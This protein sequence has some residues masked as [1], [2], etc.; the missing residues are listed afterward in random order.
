MVAKVKAQS[1]D[2]EIFMPDEMEMFLLAA[3]E[4]LIPYIAIIFK[5]YR[6]LATETQADEWFGI[7]PKEDQFAELGVWKHRKR[8]KPRAK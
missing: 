3:P 8:R 6:E 7:L 2:A 1:A 4:F 5:H